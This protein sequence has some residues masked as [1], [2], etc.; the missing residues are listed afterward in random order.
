MFL[1]NFRTTNVYTFLT[2]LNSKLII[3]MIIFKILCK[4]WRML[5]NQSLDFFILIYLAE[6]QCDEYHE[7]GL[8]RLVNNI[9]IKNN[10]NN[11]VRPVDEKEGATSV[12]TELKFLQ[13]D[14]VIFAKLFYF[15]FKFNFFFHYRTKNTKNSSRRSGL[16]W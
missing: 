11:L 14:L 7:T 6:I 13:I 3:L 1:R 2:T 9:F 5:E 10:Y 4:F 16:K 12:L 8:E 15:V